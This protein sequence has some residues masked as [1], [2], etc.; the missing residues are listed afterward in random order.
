MVANITDVNL[1][2]F[3]LAATSYFAVSFLQY[4]DMQGK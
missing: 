2:A 4:R 3:P 1:Q